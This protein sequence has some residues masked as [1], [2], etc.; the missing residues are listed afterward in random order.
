LVNSFVLFIIIKSKINAI[1]KKNY[2]FIIFA[3]NLSC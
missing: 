3:I 2:F 1:D